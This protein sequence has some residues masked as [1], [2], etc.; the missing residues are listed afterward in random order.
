[1]IDF[2]IPPTLFFYTILKSHCSPIRSTTGCSRRGGLSGM[3]GETSCC[4]GQE[5]W[6]E[7]NVCNLHLEKEY[8][9]EQLKLKGLDVRMFIALA[10]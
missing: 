8:L 7:K 6:D 9:S 5:S 4:A 1:M 2:G 3:F 10:P